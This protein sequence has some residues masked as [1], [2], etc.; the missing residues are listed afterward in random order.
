MAMMIKD[1]NSNW[2][3]MHDMVDFDALTARL[4]LVTEKREKFSMPFGDMEMVRLYLNNIYIVYGDMRLHRQHLRM[5]VFDMP[6]MVELHFSLRGTGLIDNFVDGRRYNFRPNEHN[7]F[8]M[9]E[10]DV[11]ASYCNDETY[12]FFE[13]HFT[14]AHFISLLA[15]TNEKMQ[16]FI[17]HVVN[18][19]GANMAPGGLPISFAM[20]QCIQDIMSCPYTGGL[21]PIFL[22]ARCLELLIL[23]AEAFAQQDTGYE[24]TVLKTGRDKDSIVHAYEYLLSHLS[25]PPS[26]QQLASIAG[27][28]TFKLKKGFK[29]LYDN[30]VFGC[31]NEA[32]LQQAREQLL[33]GVQIKQLAEELGYSSV[34][35]FST[36]FRKKF[37][38]PPGQAQRPGRC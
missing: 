7:I 8:Y 32:R 6:D 22:Q 15:N 5:K 30:T 23:Q 24:K 31:L 11:D 36:A 18:G 26:L 14:S 3:A 20:R 19:R 21:K 28:N 1:G 38:V 10:L 12:R 17:D 16:R 34:Q 25:D 35:H 2:F 29:E 37:G 13:V 9:P 4:P 33:D 27:I